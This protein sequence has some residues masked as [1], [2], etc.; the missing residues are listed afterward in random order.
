M[1]NGRGGRAM[2]EGGGTQALA[3]TAHISIQGPSREEH[4]TQ[5]EYRNKH[6]VDWL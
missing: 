6:N 2:S 4:M 1:E 5:S 3:Y